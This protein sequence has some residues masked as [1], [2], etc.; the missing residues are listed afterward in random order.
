MDLWDGVTRRPLHWGNAKF[1]CGY[2]P[3]MH[4]YEC[5]GCDYTSRWLYYWTIAAGALFFFLNN[6]HHVDQVNP[7]QM[8]GSHP[9]G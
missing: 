1:V 6:E 4:I 3:T 9:H 2:I 8:Q 7:H 5:H